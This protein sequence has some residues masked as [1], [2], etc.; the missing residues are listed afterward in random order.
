MNGENNHIFHTS[1]LDG[2]TPEREPT[3]PYAWNLFAMQLCVLAGFVGMSL[4]AISARVLA[5]AESGRLV[6]GPLMLAFA[7]AV[8][9]LAAWRGAV[10]RLSAAQ[11]ELASPER[12]T[13][14]EDHAPRISM[15]ARPAPAHARIAGITPTL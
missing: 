4:I 15:N 14:G 11:R 2:A 12:L 5:D 13:R 8:M 1:A 10:D 6:G 9:T 3:P 7:G